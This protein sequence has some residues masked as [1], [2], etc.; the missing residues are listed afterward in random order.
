MPYDTTEDPYVDKKTGILRNKVG[1]KT[2][3]QL[4]KAEAEITYITI[5]TLTNGSR[6]DKLVFN[7]DLLC[8]IHNEI[9][10]D[11]YNWA[12]KI[13]THDISKDWSYFAHATYIQQSLNELLDTIESDAR[14]NS[15]DVEIFTTAI[16]HYYAELNAIHPFREGNGRAIRTYLRLLAL[17]YGYDI[18]WSRM[19]FDENIIASQ[20]ALHTDNTYMHGMIKTLI[21]KL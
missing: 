17:K 19:S 1:A 14:F 18:E 9:F 10:R 7:A 8:D 3:F 11:I 6:V 2:Q 12:G 4:A 13:R 5:L 20:E 15:D 21:V 16:T